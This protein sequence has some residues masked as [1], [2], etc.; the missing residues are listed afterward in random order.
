MEQHLTIVSRPTRK[1][2][3][4]QI[5]QASFTLH[6]YNVHNFR[7]HSLN[8]TSPPTTRLKSHLPWW[9]NF[10]KLHE[11]QTSL[12]ALQSTNHY[13]INI[14]PSWS[15][16]N[17]VTSFQV[18]QWLVTHLL[19]SSHRQQTMYLCCL[20]VSQWKTHIIAYQNKELK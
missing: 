5:I 17:H 16:T 6:G 13:V 1:W 10:Q 15:V 3:L 8:Y 12:T 9:I 11:V 2:L 20:L 18:C 7:S 19:L 14:W 4:Q